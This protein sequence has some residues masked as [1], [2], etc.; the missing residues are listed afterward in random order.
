[1][2]PARALARARGGAQ[3]EEQPY[4]QNITD[5]RIGRYGDSQGSSPDD[6][7]QLLKDDSVGDPEW[8]EDELSCSN[9]VTAANITVLTSSFG[10]AVDLQRQV[11][12]ARLSFSKSTWRWVQSPRQL[13]TVTVSF[14]DVPAGA[15]AEFVPPPPGIFAPLPDDVF[16]PFTVTANSI[17]AAGRQAASAARSSASVASRRR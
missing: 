2:R 8:D 13:Y 9:L 11:I 4:S 6:W 3:S 5:E 16:F 14:V 12:G 7:L 17:S 1:M 15:A 10:A